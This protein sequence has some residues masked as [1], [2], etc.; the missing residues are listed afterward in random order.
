MSQTLEL[1][2]VIADAHEEA[3]V[4]ERNGAAF[5]VERVRE[6]LR[7][8]GKAS[9]EYTT[10]LSEGDAVMRSGYSVDWLRGRFEQWKRDGNARLVGRA[11]QYRQCTIPRRANTITAAARGREAARAV[12]DGRR[13]A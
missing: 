9:E 12:R 3:A 4:L 7:G 10:W 5:S 11:R 13:T 2:Q 8:I 6:I 1:S